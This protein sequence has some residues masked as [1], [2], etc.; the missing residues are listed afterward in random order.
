MGDAKQYVFTYK[1]IAETLVKA[2]GLHEGLWGVYMEF[3]LQATNAGPNDNELLPA[4]IIPV[5]KV[6]IQRFEKANG[7]TVD[8]A[9]VNPSKK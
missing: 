9:L 6:G 2:Q 8:A 1:E 5:M 3:G 4:V 7:L